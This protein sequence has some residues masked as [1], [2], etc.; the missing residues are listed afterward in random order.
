M[1][2][3]LV[4]S[5]A[6]LMAL[7]TWLAGW[8]MTAAIAFV[9]ALAWWH[10]RVVARCALAASVAWAALLVADAAGGRLGVLAGMLGGVFPL[11]GPVL[12]L[13]TVLLGAGIGWA[14]AV[15]GSLC[16]ETVSALRTARNM[17]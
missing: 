9:A 13:V 14:G 6:A 12:L 16:R 3:L 1:T 11:P 5:L 15:L 4:L 8:W 2:L 7:G 10:P 17:R